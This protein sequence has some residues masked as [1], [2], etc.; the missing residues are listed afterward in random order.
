LFD[1]GQTKA[2]RM[3]R[4]KLTGWDRY[5]DTQGKLE[6]W[7]EFLLAFEGTEI[8]DYYGSLIGAA[9]A[10]SSA[11]WIEEALMLQD[12]VIQHIKR[13]IQEDWWEDMLAMG[14]EYDSRKRYAELPKL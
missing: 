7:E 3:S 11:Q 9:S 1:T 10:A 8:A 6:K 4:Q 2:R 12:I 13:D 14:E 5:L